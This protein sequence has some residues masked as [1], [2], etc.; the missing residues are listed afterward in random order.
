M[1]TGFIKLTLHRAKYQF[2]SPSTLV[3][4]RTVVV[5]PHYIVSLE[6]SEAPERAP[7]TV[8]Y[9]TEGVRYCVR[10]SMDKIAEMSRI[11]TLPY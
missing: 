7:F 8:I 9:L 3:D 6:S 11:A 1:S 5:N 4:G 2:P 10:E